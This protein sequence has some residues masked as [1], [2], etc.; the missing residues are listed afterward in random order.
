MCKKLVCFISVLVLSLMFSNASASAAGLIAGYSFEGDA[1]DASGNGLDGVIM[2]DPVFVEGAVGQALDFDGDGDYVDLGAS[3]LFDVTDALT[4]AA[5]VNIRSLPQAWTAVVTKGDGAWRISTN[6]S[7]NGLHFGFENGTR[8]WQA[9]NSATVLNV[10]EWYHVAGVYDINVGAKIYINGAED[11][12]N[13]DTDGIT[14][15][16]YSVL[17][18]ANQQ[19]MESGDPRYWDGQI[20]EVMIYGRALSDNEVAAL[21]GQDSAGPQPVDPGT[22]GLVAYY[23]LETSSRG[24]IKDSSDNGLDGTIVGDPVFV[25]GVAGNALDFDGDG[26]YIDCGNSPLFGMQETNQITVAAWLNIRSIPTAWIAAVAKGEYAWRLSNVN[27]DPRFHFGITI[28]NAPDTFGIDGVTA[29]SLGEWHHVAGS[30]DGTNINVWLDGVVDANAVTTE[31]IGTNDMNVFI[32]ENPESLGRFWD[33]QIDEVY[34]YNRA[35]SDLE[36][37]FLTGL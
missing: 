27:M 25:K 20:D 21:A 12:S 19:T 11:G 2:G 33:G 14:I 10:G 29:V 6:G 37:Q 26:D 34:I 22:E 24:S 9:A 18:G 3:P 13:P 36:I 1:A 35:L 28:W 17:V 4:V 15:D 30:F 7:T 23:P 5:W 31:P 16:T 8:G 32:G